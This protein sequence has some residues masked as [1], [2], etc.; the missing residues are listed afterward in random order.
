MKLFGLKGANQSRHEELGGIG[1]MPY[2]LVRREELVRYQ[3]KTQI[4][5]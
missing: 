4:L 1:W 5:S 2:V 3:S